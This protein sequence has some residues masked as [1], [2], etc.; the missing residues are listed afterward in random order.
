MRTPFSRF[1]PRIW[2]AMRTKPLRFVLC[3]LVGCAALV[4]AVAAWLWDS[5]FRS[6]VTDFADD[7]WDSAARRMENCLR[8]RPGHLPSQLLMVRID[9]ARGRL[10]DASRR[11]D[12]L[13]RKYEDVPDSIQ[14]EYLFLRAI[15]GEFDSIEP[16][17]QQMAVTDNPARERALETLAQL[18]SSELSYDKASIALGYLLRDFPD[19]PKGHELSGWIAA[20]RNSDEMAVES[21]RRAI[22]L[23]PGRIGP[24]LKL[25]QHFDTIGKYSESLST[26]EELIGLAPDSTE[27]LIGYAVALARVNGSLELRRQTLRKAIGRTPESY[28]A[29][30]ELGRLELEYGDPDEAERLLRKAVEIHRNEPEPRFLLLSALRKQSGREADI[31][32]ELE[33]YNVCRADSERFQ[34]ITREELKKR[35][36]DE[37]LL[38]ELSEILMRS[39]IEDLGIRWLK[40]ILAIDANHVEAHCRLYDFYTSKGLDDVAAPHAKYLPS[41]K[42]KS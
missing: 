2:H 26:Y 12:D 41:R 27:I 19:N 21:Y 4:V 15:S 22:G 18:Y 36:N 25:A 37:N 10:E 32:I 24:K 5:N 17:L 34:K 23:R 8:F 40:K 20:M 6:A 33:R 11:L 29:H 14:T 28:A 42:K 13:K 3:A 30:I 1:L 7:R 39:G 16:A 35:P 9:V 31:A 38:L